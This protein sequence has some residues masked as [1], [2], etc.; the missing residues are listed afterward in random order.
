MCY[1]VSCSFAVSFIPNM[2]MQREKIVNGNHSGIRPFKFQSL[3]PFVGYTKV[4]TKIAFSWLHYLQ[5]PGD[6][7][8]DFCYKRTSMLAES[9]ASTPA[10]IDCEACNHMKSQYLCKS[11]CKS[12]TEFL[13][14][15]LNSKQLNKR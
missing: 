1:I 2:Y 9:F 8:Q 7:E 11:Y 5:I 13:E 12:A 10:E 4:I 15:N 3:L 6:K 14:A